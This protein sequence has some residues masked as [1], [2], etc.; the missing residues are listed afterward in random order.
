MDGGQRCIDEKHKGVV[1]SIQYASMGEI[2]KFA[3]IECRKHH[4]LF[5]YPAGS[6]FITDA[7]NMKTKH[8]VHAVTMRFPGSKA[9][10]KTIEKLV[11]KI[12]KIAEYMRLETVA[13][14]M[15][16]YGTGRLSENKVMKIYEQYFGQS[17]I[18]FYVH[19]FYEEPIL[20]DTEITTGFHLGMSGSG[21]AYHPWDN[22]SKC[23]CGGYPY[24]V[25]RNNK[26]YKGD[27]PNRIYCRQCSKT[28]SFGT[29]AEIRKEWTEIN[30]GDC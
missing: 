4:K 2:E 27:E 28:T 26:C 29:V 21:R 8:I 1:E 20:I 9:H 5:G 7:P 3:K 15:L 24:M 10:I 19:R 16:G 22:L 13:I 11:P 12:L 17:K 23:K 25:S 14:P 18:K 30:K 6:V